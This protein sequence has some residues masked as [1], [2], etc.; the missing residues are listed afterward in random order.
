[1]VEAFN[2]SGKVVK[3]KLAFSIVGVF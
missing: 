3:K 2:L 1:L